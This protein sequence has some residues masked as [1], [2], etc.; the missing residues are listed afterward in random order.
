[1]TKKR[2]DI[3]LVEQGIFNSRTQAQRAIMAGLVLDHNS[4]RIDKAGDSFD[5]DEHFIIK[6][7]GNKY[8]SRG[9]FKLEKALAVFNINLQDKICLDIGASTGGFTDVA[10]QQGAKMV[11]ALDVGYNQLA[12][13][14]RDHPKVEVMERVNFRFSKLADFTKGRPN[15]AMTDVSFISLDLIFPPMFEILEDNC[16]AVCLI[17]P[18]FEAGKENVGKHGIIKDPKIHQMVIEHTVQSALDNGF[19]VINLDYS[20]IKGGHGNIEF[21]IHLKKN[22]PE[23]ANLIYEG[24]I[25]DLVKAAH[26]M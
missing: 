9:G 17:K 18:Q 6:D 23:N 25:Q 2:V 26:E 12:Y 4:E 1:M 22:S 19:D 5:E 11:Y 16:D 15:F 13:K 14:L 20:P 24:S 3:L 21:L 8:V 7:D 10:L